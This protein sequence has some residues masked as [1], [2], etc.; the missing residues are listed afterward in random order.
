MPNWQRT[1]P[2]SMTV[3]E[4]K[5]R[6]EAGLKVWRA[7]GWLPKDGVR[8]IMTVAEGPTLDKAA[9]KRCIQASELAIYSLANSNA[10]DYCQA[11]EVINATRRLGGLKTTFMTAMC[12]GIAEAAAAVSG[13]PVDVLNRLAKLWLSQHF[14]PTGKIISLPNRARK[15]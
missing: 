12:E 3:E 7:K 5:K 2:K 10:L 14:K 6:M 9:R 11:I 8:K 1:P 13:E 4:I 15:Q